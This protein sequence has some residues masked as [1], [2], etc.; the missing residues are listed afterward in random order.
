MTAQS[1]FYSIIGIII[2]EFLWDTYLD[3][4]N[5]Q[6]YADAIPPELEGIYNPEE[7][8]QS[9]SYLRTNYRFSSIS[10]LFSLLMVLLFFFLNGFA[11]LDTWIRG[12]TVNPIYISLLFIGI[13]VLANT[14]ISIPFD[15][16]HTF[17]IEEKFGFN[18]TTL[19]TFCLDKL[20]GILLMLILGGGILYLI[21]WF[22]EKTG[23]HFWIY[24]WI[25][26]SVFSVFISMFYSSLIV[27]LFNKQKALEAGELRDAIQQFAQKT[28]FTLDAIYVIDGSKRSTKAN[29][30]FSGFGP[31]KRIV[32]YDTL[33]NDLDTDEI[34]GVLAHE[35]GHYKMKH[36]RY[37][38][39]ASIVTTGI[40]LY[41]LSIFIDNPLLAAALGVATPGFHIGIIV[42]GILYSPISEII[43]LF[44]NIISRKFEYQ[45]DS[46]AKTNYSGTALITA[47][48]KLSKNALSNLTPH[49]YYVFV[50]YSHPTLLQRIR[51]LAS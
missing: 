16:Y 8:Q 5:A 30:Y 36:T 27:P 33:I 21:L 7:Y 45:A 28:G 48:K 42:F 50:H 39:I 15:Y 23:T 40:T 34:V 10:S 19:K 46:F 3:Y 13:L 41:L 1:L 32:L 44:M 20:K 22:Y 35:I 43:G 18:K 6:H 17:V 12:I 9:Q 51:K 11:L 47:L 37:H 14:L 24:A 4:L 38:I 31:K 29:A 2:L 49:P 25:L 26:I